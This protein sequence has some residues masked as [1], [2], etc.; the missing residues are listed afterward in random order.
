MQLIIN[1]QYT[2]EQKYGLKIKQIKSECL[3]HGVV[4]PKFEEFV[5]GFRDTPFK[6]KSTQKSRR[7]QILELLKENSK[8][9]R[10]VLVEIIIVFS[11]F[12]KQHLSKL[13]NDKLLKRVSGR[14]DGYW[15]VLDA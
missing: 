14:K 5:H 6:G 8:L 7:E 3:A 15:K 1:S 2:N 9:T 10:D 4:E 11:N 12:I 13:Q